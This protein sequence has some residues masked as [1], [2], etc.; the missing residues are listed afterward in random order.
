[1]PSQP[2][3][4]KISPEMEEYIRARSTDMRV[5]TTCE[6]PLIFSIKVSPPKATDQVIL[7][8]HRKVYISSLQAQYIKVIN[9]RMLPRCALETRRKG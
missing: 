6:G 2:F 4:I 8:G 3:S 5:A 7:V 9:E 1:M